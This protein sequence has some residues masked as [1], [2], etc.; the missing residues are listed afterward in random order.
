MLPPNVLASATH[1][2][3][4]ARLGALLDIRDR[5]I[6]KAI[7]DTIAALVAANAP[8]L[9]HAEW[10]TDGDYDDQGG[11]VYSCSDLVLVTTAGRSMPVP[12]VDDWERDFLGHMVADTAERTGDA[13]L[14]A[15]V[16]ADA[17]DDDGYLDFVAAELSIDR[18]ALALLRRAI[19]SCAYAEHWVTRM[20]WRSP[21][22]P[23]STTAGDA[24]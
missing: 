5:F 23:A 1:T 21:P 8:C 24:A 6:T 10:E 3:P 18:D 13:A 2:E 17:V 16:D 9:A 14:G 4:R 20:E 12:F 7:K 22:L 15:I 19:E 11:T